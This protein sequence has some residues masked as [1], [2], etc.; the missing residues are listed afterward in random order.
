MELN[1]DIKTATDPIF[2]RISKVVPGIEWKV[3]APLIY[4]IKYLFYS[5]EQQRKKCSDISS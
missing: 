2:N 4:K 1:T 3:H 5:K